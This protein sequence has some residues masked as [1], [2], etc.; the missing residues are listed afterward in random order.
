M[1]LLFWK[2]IQEAKEQAFDELDFGRSD[3]DNLG[4]I[5]FK[6]HWGATSSSLTYWKYP[7]T[8]ASSSW[9][10]NRVMRRAASAAPD[11]L[12]RVAG[13]LLYKHIG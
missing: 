3:S 5:A 4:L 6:D 13:K 9:M 8:Q 2:T 7:R 12:L 11:I 1:A 10:N